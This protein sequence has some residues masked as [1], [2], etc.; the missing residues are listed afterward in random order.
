MI[1]PLAIGLV[2]SFL[3][4]PLV[5]ALAHRGRLLD[6][7]GPR[8]S[9]RTV[10]PRGGGLAIL[11]GLAAALLLRRG[12]W[13]ATP[14]VLALLAGAAAVALVGLLDDRFGLPPLPRFLCQLAAALG[15]VAGTGGVERLPLP[16]PFDVPTG[17]LASPLAVLWVLAVVNF[18]NFMD[19]ID[20]LAGLQGFVTALALALAGPE[21]SGTLLA[22]ALA[23]GC[24]GFLFFNWAPASIFLGDVGSGLV[25]YTVAAI[26]L[27]APPT[28][29][30]QAVLL[31]GT[32]LWLLLSDATTCLL[33]RVARGDRWYEAHRQHLYQRWVATGVGHARA[34][35][36]IELGSAATTVLALL[37]WRAG[38]PSWAWA[39]LALG[40]LLFG[41]EWRTVLRAEQRAT[42]HAA[43]SL[44]QRSGESARG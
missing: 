31:A 18:M 25:G 21:P 40:A 10:T 2:T 28:T 42:R 23:G 15:L 1:A 37:G 29:R 32:S 6:H 26:P 30:P 43:G 39:G 7:P 16:P 33:R 3:V 36:A 20:G 4:T 22:A 19:G 14:P 35:A 11:A 5:R 38:T 44:V 24:A 12:D 13:T 17:P 34:A 41:L 9:H 27:L 8:S